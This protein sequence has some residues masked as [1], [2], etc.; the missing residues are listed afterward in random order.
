MVRSHQGRN[1]APLSSFL[2]H[3][4]R[5]ESTPPPELPP[6]IPNPGPSRKPTVASTRT[7]RAQDVYARDYYKPVF[8]TSDSDGGPADSGVTKKG[9][10][11]KRTKKKREDTDSDFE[12]LL[13]LE[14][15][16]EAVKIE[17]SLEREAT[18]GDGEMG[19]K[20]R[21]EVIVIDE[22]DAESEGLETQDGSNRRKSTDSQ[23]S[24]LS[25]NKWFDMEDVEQV[26]LA[27][28]AD[29]SD[30]YYED[31]MEMVEEEAGPEQRQVVV[32]ETTKRRNMSIDFP[33][34]GTTPVP[35]IPSTRPL[36][37]LP[38]AVPPAAAEPRL[39]KT[40]VLK[41]PP[42]KP[43][44]LGRQRARGPFYSSPSRSVSPAVERPITPPPRPRQ[45]KRRAS[46]LPQSSSK[47]SKKQKEMPESESTSLTHTKDISL[48]NTFMKQ[49]SSPPAHSRS[50][51]AA[52][53]KPPQSS[54]PIR[55]PRSSHMRSPS[56]QA[57]CQQPPCLRLSLM[58]NENE[59]YA[60]PLSDVLTPVAFGETIRSYFRQPPDTYIKL[61]Q[62]RGDII[63]LSFWKGSVWNDGLRVRV[64]FRSN[65]GGGDGMAATTA[66]AGCS[67]STQ[68]Q[69][70]AVVDA[71]VQTEE[72]EV[73]ELGWLAGREMQVRQEV[74]ERYER[75][76]TERLKIR[77][78]R[79]LELEKEMEQ[80][81]KVELQ[82]GME[83]VRSEMENA[84][85]K[86]RREWDLGRE[87]E[88]EAELQ[89]GRMGLER[90]MEKVRGEL[91]RAEEKRRREWNL[92]RERERDEEQQQRRMEMELELEKA[93]MDMERAEEKRRREWELEREREREAEQKQRKMEMESEMENF[94]K[95]MEKAEEKRR[96]EWDLERERERERAREREK[97]IVNREREVVMRRDDLAELELHFG[98][99]QPK[100]LPETPPAV[101]PKKAKINAV[102]PSETPRP[103]QQQPSPG[104]WV[105]VNTK[106]TTGS[107][108]TLP[109]AADTSLQP[110][111]FV[112]P[113]TPYSIQNPAPV[114]P[115]RPRVIGSTS[116]LQLPLASGKPPLSKEKQQP[117]LQQKVAPVHYSTRMEI[118]RDSPASDTA[119]D[120]DL[121]LDLV[122]GSQKRYAAALEKREKETGRRNSA[123]E[124][125]KGA[126]GALRKEG[127]GK[128]ITSG[129]INSVQ[130]DKS[131]SSIAFQVQNDASELSL[132]LG[133][134]FPRDTISP[135]SSPEPS[136]MAPSRRDPRVAEGEPKNQQNL[137]I[138][139]KL[140]PPS[141]GP[142]GSARGDGTASLFIGT[143]SQFN[144]DTSSPEPDA[145][146]TKQPNPSPLGKATDGALP[147]VNRNP[148]PFGLA[149]RAG[150]TGVARRGAGGREF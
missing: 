135:E 93:R 126:N 47:K 41:V 86:R 83:K 38:P 53:I 87:R 17:K 98:D 108:I 68:A 71:G 60:V 1:Q 13:P 16:I 111:T 148:V 49:E 89:Q 80:Q 139:K 55:S 137:D 52:L 4:P 91:E 124:T 14:E 23:T 94:R 79:A 18:G 24:V 113:I 145:G 136:R 130:K 11:V 66:D 46:P 2:K 50:P 32:E 26:D 81:K 85:E 122:W 149:R 25:G 30:E 39:S 146:P 22:T 7:K 62:E 102:K 110:I 59:I 73:H 138:S 128:G 10:P 129:S 131:S 123:G 117:Q 106:L 134:Q 74:G 67:S 99:S 78:M 20:M 51:D 36:S 3:T 142:T 96:R 82:M 54:P 95:D 125:G 132:F 116:Q 63:N 118:D 75:E 9:S 40:V 58:G 8:P 147:P 5:R 92:E 19:R 64:E 103:K 115:M 101:T 42:S 35:P 109:A 105:A 12:E 43:K 45:E 104:R 65:F 27:G 120:L 150:K 84:E 114:A 121:S 31:S 21:Q 100:D 6:N 28:Q 15:L 141:A 48:L 33:P 90:E 127:G 70:A 44:A 97:E 56:L 34:S 144:R 76:F 88:R 37:P 112:S 61:T 107:T 72:V 77:D 29:S 143:F 57:P 133:S 119:S 140:T 69:A